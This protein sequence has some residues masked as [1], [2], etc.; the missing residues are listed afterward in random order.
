MDL[1]KEF[2]LAIF[3]EL[4]QKN[5][6]LCVYLDLYVTKMT[7]KLSKIPVEAMTIKNKA[8]KTRGKQGN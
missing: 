7:T 8:L 6:F 1:T 4:S 2:S 3:L 5:F